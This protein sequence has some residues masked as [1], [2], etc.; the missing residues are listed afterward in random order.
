MSNLFLT[1]S[2]AFVLVVF[3]LTLLGISWLIKG[4][5]SIKPGA[6]GRDPTKKQDESCGKKVSCGLCEGEKK[7][8]DDDIQQT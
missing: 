4:K 2:I 5:L 1:F 3:A 6:C 7:K 8:S